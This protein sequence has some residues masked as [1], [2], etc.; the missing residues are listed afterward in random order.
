M[1]NQTVKLTKEQI[2]EA[3]ET[4]TEAKL[5]SLPKSVLM[6]RPGWPRELIDDILGGPDHTPKGPS[7][8]RVQ[9]YSMLRIETAEK[10]LAAQN[11]SFDRRRPHPT[12][13][14]AA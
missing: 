5:D 2:A 3:V 7:G 1:E 14:S 6:K 11:C 12:S 10:Y 13:S 8:Y 4:E 9:F